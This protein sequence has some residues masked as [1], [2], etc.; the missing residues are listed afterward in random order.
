M[1]SSRRYVQFM[2]NVL[3]VNCNSPEEHKHR[4]AKMLFDEEEENTLML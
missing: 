3:D 1:F 4:D 2:L